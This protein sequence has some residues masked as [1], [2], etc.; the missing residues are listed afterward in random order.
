MTIIVTAVLT[1]WPLVWKT[2]K[3]QGI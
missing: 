1:G 3:C 2:W